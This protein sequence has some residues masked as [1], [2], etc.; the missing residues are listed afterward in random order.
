MYE[1]INVYCLLLFQHHLT[2]IQ[3]NEFAVVGLLEKRML[4]SNRQSQQG[5]TTKTTKRKRSGMKTNFFIFALRLRMAM[6]YCWGSSR[7]TWCGTVVIYRSIEQLPV[8]VQQWKPL[9]NV[10]L[11]STLLFVCSPIDQA[12]TMT[13]M[14]GKITWQPETKR[15][16]T[17]TS[18][19]FR[20]SCMKNN[21]KNFIIEEEWVSWRRTSET[22][23]CIV[24]HL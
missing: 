11:F 18:E 19:R 20:L 8:P 4:C 22:E 13:K 2:I 7:L 9:L 16:R 12:K 24:N 14:P 15:M 1:C 5:T 21:Q 17:R 3:V 23:K 10:F 6:H